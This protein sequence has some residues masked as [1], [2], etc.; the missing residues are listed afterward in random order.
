MAYYDIHVY[1]GEWNRNI[2]NPRPWV[3]AALH[4]ASN[5]HRSI[6][7]AMVKDVKA[8]RNVSALNWTVNNFLAFHFTHLRVLENLDMSRIIFHCLKYLIQH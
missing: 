1:G 7:S 8:V 6:H 2:N 3:C 5:E 4:T